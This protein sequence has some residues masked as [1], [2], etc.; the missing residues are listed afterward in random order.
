MGEKV[1]NVLLG[2][3]G[4]NPASAAVTNSRTFDEEYPD[5]FIQKV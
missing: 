3:S 2:T 4:Q 1:E 5:Y